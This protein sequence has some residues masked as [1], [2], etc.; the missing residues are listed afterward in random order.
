MNAKTPVIIRKKVDSDPGFQSY[1]ATTPRGLAEPLADELRDLGASIVRIDPAGV[2]FEG[3]LETVYNANLRSRLATRIL[4]RLAKFDYRN[5]QDVYDGARRILWHSYFG[6][7]RSFK[8]ETSAV[9]S[10]LRSLDFITLKVKDAIA[11]T[12]RDAFGK[13]PDVESR[14]PEVRVHVFLD[15]KWATL[16]LDTSGEPLFKRGH[17]AAIGEASVK[18]N[19]AAGILRLAKWEPGIPL[20]DPMCGA[21]TF[22]VEAGE[23]SFGWAA[24]RGRR[25][26]FENLNNYEAPLWE[27]LKAQAA[28]EEKEVVPVEIYGSDLYGR[29]LDNTRKNIEAAGLEGAVQLKQANLLEVSAPGPEGKLVTNPPYGV[30]IGDKDE[31]AKFYPELGHLLKQKFSGWTA[32][33]FSGDPELAK[34]IRLKPTRKTVLYNGPLE[35]RLYVYPMVAGG[36][37]KE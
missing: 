4:W 3:T 20:L 21:G 5:E 24:G 30:R 10:P 13:R 33:I 37:R 32:Y 7:E 31:L 18:K 29:T 15:A 12:F 6:L 8:I 1:Y 11:D 26:G 9:K 27:K 17:R 34:L 2:E 23:M 14:E 16:Y 22:L 36:N 35:C 28:S 19:L 25:F